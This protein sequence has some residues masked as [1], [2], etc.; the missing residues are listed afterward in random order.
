MQPTLANWLCYLDHIN[1]MVIDPVQVVEARH[2]MYNN[3]SMAF[4]GGLATS[5]LKMGRL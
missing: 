1:V 3:F 4:P 2:K 5:S